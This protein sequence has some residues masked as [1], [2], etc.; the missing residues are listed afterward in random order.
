MFRGQFLH[1]I[2]QKGRTSLP[3][4]FREL[5]ER[6]GDTRLI[7]TPAPFDPCLHLYPLAKWEEFER[8][9]SE[10][11]SLDPDITRFRRLYISPALDVE[12]DKAGRIRL[13]A[14]F[15]AQA[16]LDGEVFWAGMGNIVELWSKPLWDKSNEMDTEQFAQFRAKVQELIR[17]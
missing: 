11:P 9:I 3:A 13:N 8:K 15:R 4:R 14:E 5:L 12:P 10:L 7:C 17:I 1:T 16:S 2:D 6:G